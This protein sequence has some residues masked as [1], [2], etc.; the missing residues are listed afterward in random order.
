MGIS[1]PFAQLAVRRKAT[2]SI[3]KGFKE[4]VGCGGVRLLMIEEP[5]KGEKQKTTTK[6]EGDMEVLTLPIRCFC[7]MGTSSCCLFNSL[8][9]SSQKIFSFLF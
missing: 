1:T 7:M 4:E 6:K 9:I 2:L 3:K 5:H 8:Y